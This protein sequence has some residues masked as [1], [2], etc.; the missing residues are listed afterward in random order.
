MICFF[1]TSQ[2]ASFQTISNFFCSIKTWSIYIL[3]CL[4]Y[5]SFRIITFAICS[6]LYT[7]PV[8]KQA[9]PSEKIRSHLF[10]NRAINISLICISF[11][12]LSTQWVIRGFCLNVRRR[13]LCAA[14]GLDMRHRPFPVSA[15]VRRR[16]KKLRHLASVRLTCMPPAI[17]R[18]FIRR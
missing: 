9:C 8:L 3:M 4:L 14:C 11:V 2:R 18:E 16:L 5:F 6:S 10:M 7:R 12:T 1:I 15:H 13:L 17:T